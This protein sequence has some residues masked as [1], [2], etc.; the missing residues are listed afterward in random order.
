MPFHIERSLS[1]EKLMQELAQKDVKRFRKIQKTL[2]LLAQDPKHP[3]LNSHKMVSQKGLNG[4]DIWESYVENNVPSAWRV[5]W[6]YGPAQGV[7]T[8]VAITPHP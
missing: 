4:E 6:Y 1:V 5:F 3:G 8:V 7:I 2:G